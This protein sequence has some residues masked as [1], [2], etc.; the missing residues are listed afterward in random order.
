MIPSMAAAQATG[1]GWREAAKACL[2][3][4]GTMP[5]GANLGFVYGSESFADELPDIVALLGKTT[6]VADWLGAIVPGVLG[7]EGE[8]E[9]QSSLAIMVGRFEPDAARPFVEFDPENLQSFRTNHGEWLTRQGVA[10]ALVHG[11]PRHPRLQE[12]ITGLSHVTSGFLLGGLTSGAAH[13]VQMAGRAKDG[14]GL[15]GVLFGDKAPLVS[16][17]T[18]SCVPIGPTHRVT[19]VVDNVLITLDGRPALDLLK[20]EAG[21]LIARDLRRAAGSIHVALPIAGSDMEDYV[22]RSLVGIDPQRGWLAVSDKLEDGDEVMFV[23]RDPNAAQEDLK[24]M[25]EGI[26]R[27]L[28]GRSVRGGIYVSCIARGAHMFGRAGRETEMIRETLGDF[29]MIGFSA[30][31]EICRDRLYAYTGVLTLFL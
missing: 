9:G 26:S 4:L 5:D 15:S 6:P 14:A 28:D 2:A 21:E 25:L 22:V 16:G 12:L 27:R 17:L 20:I 8:A 10:T 3:Q 7:P 18:Q 19:E 24:N 13:T 30:N 11:D 31:G 29:P 23:R 1:L